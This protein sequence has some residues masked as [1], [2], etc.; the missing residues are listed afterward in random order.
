MSTKNK[1]KLFFPVFT[2]IFIIFDLEVTNMRKNG[3]QLN[4]FK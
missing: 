3:L 1:G 4:N 2:M